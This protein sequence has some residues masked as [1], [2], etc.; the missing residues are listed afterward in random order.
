MV[1]ID[2]VFNS[3]LTPQSLRLMLTMSVPAA[4]KTFVDRISKEDLQAI[5]SPRAFDSGRPS[6]H[7][8]T[9]AIRLVHEHQA[10]IGICHTWHQLTLAVPSGLQSCTSLMAGPEQCSTFWLLTRSI[11]PSGRSLD[12]S[13]STLPEASR[14]LL[15]LK[16]QEICQEDR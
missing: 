13:M 12:W 8:C 11:L 6:W 3:N 1:R 16:R 10:F 7:H 5:T 9:S 14:Y 4:V 2:I 15:L